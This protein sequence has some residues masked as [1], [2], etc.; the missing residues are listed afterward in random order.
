LI[1]VLGGTETVETIQMEDKPHEIIDE[2]K[3]IIEARDASSL[4]KFVNIEEGL[5]WTPNEAENVIELLN[6]DHEKYKDLLFMLRKQAELLVNGEE[7]QYS[8]GFFYFNEAGKLNV[9]GYRFILPPNTYEEFNHLLIEINDSKLIE[10]SGGDLSE[11]VD[12]GLFGPGLYNISFD[13][14]YPFSKVSK[15]IEIEALNFAEFEKEFQ[16]NLHGEKI[17]V[18]SSLSETN[19]QVNNTEIDLKLQEN[20]KLDV[21]PVANEVNVRGKR[22]FPWGE[23]LSDNI[24]IGTTPSSTGK[25]QVQEHYEITPHIIEDKINR[26]EISQLLSDFYDQL[27]QS[28]HKKDSSLLNNDNVADEVK[29]KYKDYIESSS[30]NSIEKVYK[31]DLYSTVIDFSSIALENDPETDE[32]LFTL[33]VRLYIKSNDNNEDITKYIM[34]SVYLKY[35][36]SEWIIQLDKGSTFFKDDPL[37]IN[38]NN[39]VEIVI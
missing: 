31:G 18:A 39:I 1:F 21:G 16:I 13:M 3:E 32:D 14:Y 11:G 22:N 5:Y 36:E 30:S 33:E 24:I 10:F 28:F 7:S 27:F 38:N 20:V 6:A 29:E 12:L 34:K 23:L 15:K 19:I 4:Y 17:T 26:R 25:N 35:D 37:D 9:R 8:S 2:L